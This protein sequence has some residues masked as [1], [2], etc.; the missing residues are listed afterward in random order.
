MY[1]PQ[2]S[3][4]ADK[5]EA[6]RTDEALRDRNRVFYLS[7]NLLHLASELDPKRCLRKHVE[8][9]LPN[10]TQFRPGMKT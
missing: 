1:L 7:L 3:Y 4:L 8:G 5:M 2:L 9:D 10:G 6:Q